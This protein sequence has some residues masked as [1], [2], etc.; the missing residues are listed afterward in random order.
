MAFD[1]RWIP[2]PLP[3]ASEGGSARR[4]Q[5]RASQGFSPPKREKKKKRIRG[6]GRH[7][8]LGCLGPSEPGRDP[9]SCP[10]S[11]LSRSFQS[12]VS[13]A[14]AEPPPRMLEG[15]GPVPSGAVRKEAGGS[16]RGGTD[17]ATLRVCPQLPGRAASLRV[18]GGVVCPPTPR[19]RLSPGPDARQPGL[20]AEASVPAG[21]GMAPSTRAY[22]FGLGAAL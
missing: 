22:W 11:R 2:S 10:C 6:G 4:R 17:G 18:R 5:E 21:R 20:S 1:F 19:K 13:A 8:R 15:N 16:R 14:G 3:G 7:L 9:A 12:R